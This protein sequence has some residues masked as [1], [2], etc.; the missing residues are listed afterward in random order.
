MDEAAAGQFPVAREDRIVLAREQRDVLQLVQR[1]EA[2]AQAVV[3]VV[4]V[5]GD[6]VGEVRDLR[7]EARL[8]A[9]DEA[10]P[11]LAERARV[12][13]R[14][15]LQDPLA[16]LEREVEPGELGVAFLELVDHAQRLQVVLEAAV[17][18]H[19]VVQHVLAGV[20]EGRVAEVVREADGLG[21]R[22]RER[23]RERDRAAD[24]RDLDRMREPRAVH[25]A[26]VV[27]E[28]LRLVDQATE[29]VRM[30]DAVAVA[31]ELAAPVRGRL[32]VTPAAGAPLERGPGREPDVRIAAAPHAPARSSSRAS[33]ASR[34]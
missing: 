17:V 7:L 20:P 30:D 29:G 14:A 28:D 33:S 26:F 9:L 22:L 25:V 23:E 3:D 12:R 8:A 6:G 13:E 16:R 1:D 24:L 31:L 2:R 5:V 27:D 10:P 34:G 32:R 11:E 21:Q 18:A 4:V 19:A 15:V